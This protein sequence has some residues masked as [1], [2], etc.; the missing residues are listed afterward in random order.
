[1]SDEQ[2]P[3]EKQENNLGQMHPDC[4]PLLEAMMVTRTIPH[5]EHIG[6]MVMLFRGMQFRLIIDNSLSIPAVIEA[7]EKSLAE[8]KSQTPIEVDV[9]TPLDGAVPSKLQ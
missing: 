8:L 4:Y 7:M 3:N 6:C 5:S 9:D 1:M 2:P